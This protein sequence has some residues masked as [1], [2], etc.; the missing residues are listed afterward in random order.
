[1]QYMQLYKIMS[2]FGQFLHSLDIKSC[3]MCDCILANDNLLQVARSS[4]KHRSF[5]SVNRKTS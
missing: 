3:S 5:S 1:M 2:M 4:C